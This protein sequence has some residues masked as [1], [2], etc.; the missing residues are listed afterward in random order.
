[1]P[2]SRAG[3]A[4]AAFWIVVFGGGAIGAGALQWLGPPAPAS[5]APLPKLAQPAVPALAFPSPVAEPARQSAPAPAALPKPGQPVR[6]PLEALLEQPAGLP[7][8]GPDGLTPMRAYAAGVD[9]GEARPRI[10]LLFGGIGLSE[11]DSEDAL[12]AMPSA[13]S[14]AVSAYAAKPEHLLADIRAGGHEFLLALPMQPRNYPVDDPGN[15]ALLVDAPAAQNAKRLD[16][17]LSRF[18]GYAGVTN[19]GDN[20][21]RGERFAESPLIGGVLQTLARRGLFYIAA[22]PVGPPGAPP[23]MVARGIDLVLDEPAVRT[24]IDA[25]LAKLEA[26]ARERGAVIGLATMPRPVT[27]DRIAAWA[28]TLSQHGIALVPVSAVAAMQAIR[29]Q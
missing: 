15:Q 8:V 22:D 1:M 24:E 9:P 21:M 5:I 27:I 10:A 19:A 13:V 3:R 29:T 6:A 2:A 7:R 23:A 20:G 12:R 26:L 18:A 17:S 4:L 16:W 28:A 11:R 14:F 25:K